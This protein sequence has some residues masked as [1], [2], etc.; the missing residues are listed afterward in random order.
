[1]SRAEEI[2]IQA[3]ALLNGHFLYTSGRHGAQYM[4]CA[5][6]LQY[7][8]HT[9][10]LAKKIAEGF[11]GEKVDIVL[12]PAI[13]GIVWGYELARALGAKSIFA[14]R[15]NGTMTLRRGFDIPQNARVVVAEDVYT[16]GGTIREIIEI[17]KANGATLVGVGVIV[18]RTGGKMDLS[19][20]AVAAYSTE[21]TSYPPE[22]CP[23]CKQGIPI[24][25]PGSRT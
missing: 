5:K 22:E 4:Q 10:E 12:A 14:E 23:L 15:E 19:T 20:K 7:P 25:K 3:D 2:L 17:V 11:A 18:D 8:Q 21:I 9:E 13:G 16:T 1:M 6:V 24:T